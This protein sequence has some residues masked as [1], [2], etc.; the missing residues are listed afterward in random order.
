MKGM[1]QSICC[2][3]SAREKSEYLRHHRTCIHYLSIFALCTC[4]GL[5]NSLKSCTS[6]SLNGRT[7]TNDSKYQRLVRPNDSKIGSNF[8]Q[9]TPNIIGR[10]NQMIPNITGQFNFIVY[11]CCVMQT[12]FSNN[13]NPHCGFPRVSI[14]RS[15][16]RG[17]LSKVNQQV[18]Y[19]SS[20]N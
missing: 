16:R 6:F 5:R 4:F 19:Y 1:P 8:I 2:S 13:R 10:L 11:L 14:R 3:A 12:T 20:S 7:F 17:S 9:T 15:L 18:I